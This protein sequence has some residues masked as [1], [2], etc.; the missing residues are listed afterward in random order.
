VG[1]PVTANLVYESTTPD[2]SA[3]ATHGIYLDPFSSF[4]IRIG[5]YE[6]SLATSPS[7]W[8]SVALA[9]IVPG[10][11][12]ESIPDQV[13]LLADGND[14]PDATPPCCGLDPSTLGMALEFRGPLDAEI[15]ASDA[16]LGVPP[17]LGLF[18]GFGSIS[19]GGCVPGVNCPPLLIEFSIDSVT[20]VP[21]PGG[22]ALAL[23]ACAAQAAGR[24]RL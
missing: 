9:D 20:L 5:G 21:E 11:P 7:R 2:A 14:A 15:L 17:D 3:P 1:A 22:G 4:S 13:A 19:G 18:T 24:R 8:F 23:L 10:L 16:L 6:V 12:E